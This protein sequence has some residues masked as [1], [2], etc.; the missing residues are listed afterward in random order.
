MADAYLTQFNEERAV[1]HERRAKKLM[2]KIQK[3]KREPTKEERAEGQRLFDIADKYRNGEY[4]PTEQPTRPDPSYG[5]TSMTDKEKATSPATDR[6]YRGMFCDSDRALSTDGWKSNVEFLRTFLQGRSDPRFQFR[7]MSGLTGAAGA[8]AIPEQYA[9][10]MLDTALKQEIV[11]NYC[12][13]FP[14]DSSDLYVPGW[15]TQDMSGGEIAGFKMQWLGES[16]TGTAQTGKL[17]SIHLRAKSGVIY[18]NV[19]M[20]LLQ[21]AKGFEAELNAQLAKAIADGIDSALINNSDA[22]GPGSIL[23]ADCLI[24]VSKEAGQSATT[25]NY[26]NVVKMYAR[27][28]DHKNAIFIANHTV[29]PQILSLGKAVGT[30]GS[31]VPVLNEDNGTYR[32]LGKP[33]ILSDKCPTLGTMGDILYVNLDYMALGMRKDLMIETSNANRWLQREN[34]FRI[35]VR[36]DAAP[37]LSKA[38]EPNNGDSLGPFIALQTRS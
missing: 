24:E 30:G 6:S 2:L 28:L 10:E 11:R 34:S 9:K 26:E 33:V 19:S 17:R 31:V 36:M 3:E 23:G 27:Q 20:E 37:M 21:D 5:E 38:L 1:E 16:Q 7:A 29:L 4:D 15:D 14:M 18:A 32:L 35:I 12:K 8:F 25:I 13:V 22:G